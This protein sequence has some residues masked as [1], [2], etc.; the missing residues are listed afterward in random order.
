MQL[1]QALLV[2]TGQAFWTA[3]SGL[4]WPALAFAVIAFI[5]RGADAFR[6][7]R[8]A[9]PQVRINLILFAIDIAIVTPLLVMALT[10]LGGLMQSAGLRL[11]S[12]DHW[13]ALPVWAVAIIAVFCGDFIGYWRHRLE[14]TPFLWPAHAIHHSDTHMTWTTGLRFH[15][16]NRVTTALIDTTFLALLGLPMWALM[17]NNLT[18]HFYGLFIHMDLPWTYGLL[19]RV[20]VSPAMH[21]WHHIRDAD[22]AGVN[23]ATVSSVF[24]QAF[25]TYH[26]PRP[27]DAPLG[28]RDQIGKGAWGQIAWPFVVI[29]RALSH[30][31]RAERDPE[32]RAN[33]AE[34]ALGSGSPLRSARN[35]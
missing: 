23:F 35:D 25:G 29:F 22:G 34:V 3:F 1:V 20:F 33:D 8:D 18:R 21:R 31:G 4:I 17:I 30:S 16:L 32:P 13:S 6:V 19:S 26:V 28:V 5:V 11:F 2:Q 10:F 12:A 24:D 27:C 9:G 14:H 15:P 7:A